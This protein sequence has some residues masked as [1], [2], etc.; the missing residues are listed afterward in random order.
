MKTKQNNSALGVNKTVGLKQIGCIFYSAFLLTVGDC[1]TDYLLENM[2]SGIFYR[3]SFSGLKKAFDTVHHGRLI[4]K[5]YDNGVCGLELD[6]FKS[7]LQ[8]WHQVTNR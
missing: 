7:Y 4:D 6:W 3:S 8:D 5:L 1:D 2:N